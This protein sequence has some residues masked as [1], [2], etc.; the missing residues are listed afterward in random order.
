ME[1][2][3]LEGIYTRR[4]VRNYTSEPVEGDQVLEI[5]KSGMW[6]PSGL[7]NQ[8]WRFVVIKDALM[9]DGLAQLT[10]YTRVLKDAPVAIAVFIDHD[11]MYNDVKDHQSVGACIQNMLLAAHALNLGAVWLGEILKNAVKVRELLDLSDN[12]ELMAVI[13]I[14]HPQKM[15]RESR[16]RDIG[17]M[18]IREY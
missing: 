15:D 18:L 10:K 8:P 6:A 14:G 5:I 2:D 11:A 1:M 12:L 13:A 3:I 9:R 4:S 17:E 16:R 7:N